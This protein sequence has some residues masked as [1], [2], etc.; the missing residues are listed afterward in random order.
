MEPRIRPFFYTTAAVR[1]SLD[2]KKLAALSVAIVLATLASWVYHSFFFIPFEPIRIGVVDAEQTASRHIVALTLPDV[3]SLRGQTAV[4]AWRL[5]NGGHEPKRIGLLRDGLQPHR[6]VLTPDSDTNWNIVLTPDEVW[7][8]TVGVGDAVRSLELTGDADVWSVM[9]GEIRNYHL[10]WGGPLSTAVLPTS[11]GGYRVWLSTFAFFLLA[12]VLFV[13]VGLYAAPALVR[14]PTIVRQS[15]AMVMS[16]WKRHEVTFERGAAWLGLVAIAIA[17]PIFEVVSNSPEFF[18]ARSTPAATIVVTVLAICFGLPLILA[19]VERTIRLLSA[20][21]ASVFT[22]A[23]VA[24]LIAAVVMPWL[25]RGDAVRFPWDVATSAAVGIA[26]GLAYTR[27]RGVRQF[28]TALAPA[29]LIVPALFLL[30]PNV[31]RHFQP[32]ESGAAVQ[33][34][35]RTPSIVLVIF[36]ELP[37]NS[38]LAGDGTLDAERYPNFAAL[39]RGAYWFRNASTVA[40]NTS[41]AVPVI[42]SGRYVASDKAGPSLRHYP[43]NLFTSLARHYRIF[44]SMRFQRLCPSGT[45][46]QNAAI[47]DDTVR[48]LVSDLSL[49]WLHIVLPETL[50][51]ELPAVVGEWAE[52]GRAREAPRPGIRRG[53][54]G[55]FAEFLAAIDHQPAR[56]HVIHLV[57]PHM[58]FEYVPS[59]RRYSAPD[60]QQTRVDGS[61][62]FDKAS[63]ALADTIHQRHLAQVGYADHLIGD[64]IAHLRK[65]GA[66]DDALVIVTSDHGASYREGRRRRDPRPSQQNLSDI[67]HVPLFIKLPGQQQ[68]EVVDRIVETVDIFPT[69]LDVVGAKASFRLDGRSLVDGRDSGRKSFFLRNRNNTTPR[70]LGDLAADRASSLERKER[71]FGRGD[72]Q[73]LYAPASARHLLGTELSRASLKPAADTQVTV[74]RLSQYDSVARE[75]DPLPIYV[76]GVLETRRAD[77]LSVVVVVNGT[78]AAIAQSY[79]ARGG[80]LFGT[81]IPESA[82]RNGKNTV[83]A[84]VVDGFPVTDP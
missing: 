43:V 84:F 12:A 73:G 14:L 20:R 79:Q 1:L 16:G 60:F 74:D 64:L 77:P 52:F 49:V 68:G 31:Q 13:P 81:L 72:L 17:Q 21:A 32:S 23:I 28:L 4:L 29:A 44:A 80:H 62:L 82:L 39:A 71:R 56:M 78:I 59:G 69:I 50:T 46:E 54:E 70:R 42:L 40:Y 15:P 27:T 19:A 45:C 83:E 7:A 33:T 48:Q 6:V 58:P 24:T 3:S 26:C 63:A 5:R 36:D 30:D 11:T 22:G 41:D 37:T 57:L 76:S 18:P 35:Q 8:L 47:P 66:Y 25:R 34:V 75:R 67:L 61:F 55:W 53:R 38:L 10:H 65:T 9:S 51:E 2:G